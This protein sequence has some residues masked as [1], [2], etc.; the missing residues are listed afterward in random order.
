MELG[1]TLDGTIHVCVVVCKPNWTEMVF[2]PNV[3]AY[4]PQSGTAGPSRGAADAPVAPSV[5]C[6]T[7]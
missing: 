7:V 6:V 3:D 4:T 1:T 2:G 5:T